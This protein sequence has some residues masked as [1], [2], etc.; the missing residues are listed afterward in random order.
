[1]K[2]VAR[3]CAAKIGVVPSL[4]VIHLSLG[5][6]S[7]HVKH[8]MGIVKTGVHVGWSN[9]HERIQ[10]YHHGLGKWHRLQHVDEVVQ[11]DLRGVL[12]GVGRALVVP[13]GPG[14][15]GLRQYRGVGVQHGAVGLVAD[16]AQGLALLRAC[17][18][19]HGQG[20]V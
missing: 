2:A 20:L 8:R 7:G 9:F 6:N 16:G 11:A 19:Q 12:T 13:R 3:P 4:Q 10:R 17:V 14:A 18:A 1:M 15:P 5:A